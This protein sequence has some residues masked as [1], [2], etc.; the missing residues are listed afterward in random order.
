MPFDLLKSTRRNVFANVFN[1]NDI[2]DN[3]FSK[4]LSGTSQVER[5]T[6]DD[7][8]LVH[9]VDL[10]GV[11]PN[12]VL[13]TM[14]GRQLDIVAKRKAG[15]FKRSYTL[16]ESLDPSGCRAKLEYGVLSIIF[17][18]RSQ[19][20]Q[21]PRKITIESYD[22]EKENVYVDQPRRHPRHVP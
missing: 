18:V 13:V 14:T 21:E 10:P 11:K 22:T 3:F 2:F 7:K 9:E 8:Q 15:D 12:D 17:P 20:K 5:T 1:E 4:Q 6:C 16:S 19:Q